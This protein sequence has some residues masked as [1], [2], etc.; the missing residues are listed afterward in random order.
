MNRLDP[1]KQAQVVAA[2]VEG[3]SIRATVRMT[4]VAKNTVAK[5]L[6]ALGAA[7]SK[8]LDKK[9][10]NLQCKRVQCDE[11][12]SFIGAK[13]KN[14]TPELLAKGHAGDIW[15]W[16]AMDADT[17]LICSWMVGGRDSWAAIQFINDLKQRLA[18]RV[19]LTTDGF[20]SYLYAVVDTFG[21][22]VDYAMLVK[23]YGAPTE[24]EK[25]YSPAQCL[26]CK[27]QPISGDPDP[28]HISTSYIE[29]QNLTMRMQ[30]RRFTRLTNAFSKKLENH[31][32]SLA[33]HY[34]HYNFVRIHQSLRVTPAIAAGV[35]SRLW[36]IDDI[37]R[38]LK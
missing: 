6:V 37:I 30:N 13:E 31:V 20:H 34:M 12:W 36:S 22:E 25:R 24:A 26:G 9:L 23:L 11:I 27:R 35:T 33:L 16:V 1:R 18:N 28:A 2:L 5:L 4:G 38:L 21:G 29:R 15:T 14:V 19:Q 10:V 32:A 8:Y 3:N 7:C 17:K